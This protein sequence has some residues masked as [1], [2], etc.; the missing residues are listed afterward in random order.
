MLGEETTL[1]GLAIFHAHAGHDAGDEFAVVTAHEIV[2]E[3]DEELA[4]T[5]I[6]LAAGAP[7]ELVVDTAGVVSFG[8]DDVEAAQFGNPSAFFPHFFLGFDFVDGA[9]PNIFGDVETAWVCSL[10]PGPGHGFGVTAQDDVSAAAGHVGGNG[11][12]SDPSSLGDDVGLTGGMFGEC[13]EEF[14]PNA[15]L[16]QEC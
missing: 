4:A 13:V 16:F 7:A 5:G 8:A 15:L 10:E 2:I 11:D 6:A 12:G 3:C 14:V 1:D 9:F